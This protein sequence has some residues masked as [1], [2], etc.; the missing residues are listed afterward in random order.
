MIKKAFY[1]TL[2]LL[3][4]THF[5][6]QNK[7]KSKIEN[8]PQE[9]IFV[10]INSTLFLTGEHILYSVYCLDFIKNT[11]STL[12]KIAYVELIDAENKS[13]LKQ[14]VNLKNGNGYSDIFLSSSVKTGAYKLI[15]YTQWMRNQK[16]YFEENIFIINPFQKKLSLSTSET[17]DLHKIDKVNTKAQINVKTNKEKYTKREKINLFFDKNNIQNISISVAKIDDLEL[18]QNKKKSYSLYEFDKEKNTSNITF[19]PELR[20]E[21]FEGKLI[22]KHAINNK[23]IAISFGGENSITKISTTDK[24]GIFYFNIN[25]PYTTNEVYLEVLEDNNTKYS[26]VLNDNTKINKEFSDF[27][28]LELSE[29]LR[30][31]IKQKSKYIQ[32]ENA[33]SSVKQPNYVKEVQNKVVFYA[34]ENT[35][36][37]VLD[38]FKRFKTVKEVAVEILKDVWIEKENNK[39]RF[40]LRDINLVSDSNLETL[41][42]VD[43]FIITNH[44]QFI[45]SDALKIYSIDVVQEKYFFGDK[46][47]QGIL[48][49]ETFKN[50][51]KPLL[52]TAQKFA[53]LKPEKEKIYFHPNYTTSKNKNI[54][55]Y[56]TQ[57]Y[58]NPRIDENS[59]E[60][61][62]FSSDVSG[63]FKV[64]VQGFT[65]EGL[66]ISEEYY[67]T[68]K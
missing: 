50:D 40:R 7:W 14:K 52:N 54:P 60:V 20:G 13:V 35:T 43:G 48:H 65:K 51:F 5:F 62:F 15:S 18:P 38:D 41:L 2:I 67:F 11:P 25:N 46:L 33:F 68:V 61:I 4:N 59:K 66:P 34:N 28:E 3:V 56:R 23:N 21:L 49:I 63:K 36:K 44:Q 12:S 19:I 37:Y 6:A 31:Y 8:L 53:L 22:S 16:N 55:D 24:K 64:D 57:L 17:N 29:N 1:I 42:I 39:N 26:I 27:K 45:D 58:W 32:I 47:Y 9:K 30:K 10:H